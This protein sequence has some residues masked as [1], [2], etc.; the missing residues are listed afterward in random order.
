MK[1]THTRRSWLLG[2]GTAAAGAAFHIRRHAQAAPAVEIIETKVISHQPNLYHGWP[3][4]TRRKCGELLLVC[5]GGREAHV[6]PFGRV[7]LMRS[8]DDGQTWSWPRV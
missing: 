8:K 6:C 2:I 1:T 3:T 4:L 7:E 5:S